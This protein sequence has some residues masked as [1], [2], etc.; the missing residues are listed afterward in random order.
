M[1]AHEFLIEKG[2]LSVKELVPVMI[3][4]KWLKEFSE[5]EDK[6]KVRFRAE[7][8]IQKFGVD[9]ETKRYLEKKEV[10]SF[11]NSIPLETLKKLVGFKVFDFRDK[12][13][14]EEA[15]KDRSLDE[16]LDR[17]RSEDRI[18]LVCDMLLEE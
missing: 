17:L 5:L 14:L 13:L 1:D 2:I 18:K 9:E 12:A 10:F 11:L 6:S 3:V 15:V 8:Y 7:K 16:L 4:E